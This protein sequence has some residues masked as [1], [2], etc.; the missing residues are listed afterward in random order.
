LQD[1][2]QFN[3]R[4]PARKVFTGAKE[5]FQ[6]GGLLLRPMKDGRICADLK[7]FASPEESNLRMTTLSQ[8]NVTGLL[9][10]WQQGD[11]EALDRLTPLVYD[12][13]RR[14][15]HRYIQRE[16][17]GQTL[18]TTALVNEA[19]LR[20]INQQK[21]DWQNRAH[22]FAVTARVMRHILIDHAR[23]RHYLKYGGEAQ[24]V[25][26][27]EAN[28]M[29]EVRAAELVALDEALDELAKLDPRKS[30]VVELRY[31]GGLSLEETADVLEISIMTVRRDWRTAKAWLY[32][33]VKRQ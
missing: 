16:R 28:A 17:A 1:S 6:E 33:A 26:L 7:L 20:L 12:E 9:H 4:E 29:S 5:N 25:S 24:Q 15:A 2:S 10:E 22:F 8:P 31:F 3:K 14:M 27:T 11:R 18:E 13:L 19:Y 32:K 21:M 30:R 23:R